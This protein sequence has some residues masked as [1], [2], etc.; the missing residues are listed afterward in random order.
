MATITGRVI[1]NL[2]GKLG[3][4]IHCSWR[5]LYV[6]KKVS[7]RRKKKKGAA[8]LPQVRKVELMS[9]FLR[10]F[11]AEIKKGFYKKNSKHTPWT[12]ALKYNLDKA[13]INDG[14]GFAI[15]YKNVRIADGNLEGAWA[16]KMNFE[17]GST[18]R[19]TWQMSSMAEQT[20]AGKDKAWIAIYNLTDEILQNI[21]IVADREAMTAAYH[22]KKDEVGHTFH[23]WIFFISP[24]G[25]QVS[26]SDYIGSGVLIV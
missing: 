13:V 22:L 3:N 9:P 18:I 23:A 5:K 25:K 14:E 11:T 6:A 20:T 26:T 1:G 19:I 24:D 8:V 2:R 10:C 15:N 16:A 17:P 4:V 7:K 21:Q 12:L